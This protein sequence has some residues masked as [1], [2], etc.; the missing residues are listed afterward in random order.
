MVDAL[1]AVITQLE[2]RNRQPIQTLVK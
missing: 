1:A 2:L